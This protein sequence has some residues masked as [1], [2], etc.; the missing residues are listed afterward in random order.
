V[1]QI[2]LD[3]F[4]NFHHK[5]ACKPAAKQAFINRSRSSTFPFFLS[6]IDKKLKGVIIYHF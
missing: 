2:G 1:A 5:G 4:C 3:S 6:N